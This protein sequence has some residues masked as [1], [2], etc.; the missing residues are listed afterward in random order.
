MVTFGD[1]VPDGA[2]EPGR[3]LRPPR[4][5]A[6]VTPAPRPTAVDVLQIVDIRTKIVSL[7]SLAIGSAYAA[8]AWRAF[9]PS[10]FALMLAATLAVDMGTTAFNSYYD[11]VG[12]VDTRETDV[13]RWKALVQRGIAPSVAF[14]VAAAMFALAAALGL[15][16]GAL[17][18]WRVVGVGAV[19]MAVGY[20]YSGGPQPIARLPVGEI[21]AGGLLG[22]VLIALAA[23]VQ[24]GRFDAATVW[25]GL[26]FTALIATILSVNNA[27]DIEGDAK[28]GRRTLAVVLGRVRAE[29]AI[30]A[31]AVLALALAVLL[32]PLGVLPVAA[33]AAIGLAAVVGA[34]TLARMGRAPCSHATKAMQMAGISTIFLAASGAILA[35]LAMR[36]AG[37]P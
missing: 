34:R 22:S 6:T 27:C 29:R 26:P 37:W 2:A 11:F 30:R 13:E 18:D 28:A 17:F 12:G 7:S 16:L 8:V 19:C 24:G 14:A 35:G 10:R 9:S 4:D 25:I 20:L 21:F 1:R 3:G 32:V 33:L 31:Q 15:A 23:F 5:A 36:A